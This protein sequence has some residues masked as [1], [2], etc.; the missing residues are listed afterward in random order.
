MDFLN[1][2]PDLSGY[3]PENL[4]LDQVG[5]TAAMV[6]VVLLFLAVSVIKGILKTI[7]TL[8]SFSIAAGAFLFGFL[9]SPPIIAEFIPEAASWMPLLAGSVCALIALI[10]IQLF[11]GIFSGKKKK[12][13]AQPA[14]KGKGRNPIAPVFG[15]LVG[16]AVLFSLL[17]GL[18][19]MGSQAELEHL[20]TFVNEGENEAGSRPLLTQI[21]Q[22]LDQSPVGEIH[23]RFDPLFDRAEHHL[24]QL[25]IISNDRNVL[26]RALANETNQKV[27]STPEIKSLC[28]TGK[29]QLAL[30]KAG[31]FQQL[32]TDERF[33]KIAA[34][35]SLRR[36]L[37]KI[38]LGILFPEPEPEESET[39]EE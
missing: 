13:Q 23:E 9:Y 35:P 33:S 31:Q 34:R 28:L 14:S 15:L 37:L 26:A 4:P 17:S 21:C 30:G 10:I 1:Q 12:A 29:E 5:L 25:M 19:Y 2:L 27:I 20:R 36:E 16:V 38:D 39:E 24:A 3:L 18:R 6:I 22:W 32:F 7:I 11:L 8:F